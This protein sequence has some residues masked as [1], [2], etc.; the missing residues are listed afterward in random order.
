MLKIVQIRLSPETIEI[1][2]EMLKF[3][4]SGG[5]NGTG[6]ARLRERI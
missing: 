3:T 4:Y 6:M 2:I 1:N 5:V